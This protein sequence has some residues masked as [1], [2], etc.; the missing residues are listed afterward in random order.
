LSFYNK[1]PVSPILTGISLTVGADR[2]LMTRSL[3][4]VALALAPLAEGRLT[5]KRR[6][7]PP[8]PITDEDGPADRILRPPP[9]ADPPPPITDEDGSADLTLRPPPPANRHSLATLL[10]IVRRQPRVSAAVLFATVLFQEHVRIQLA[11]RKA[12]RRFRRLVRTKPKPHYGI[13]IVTTAALPWKTGTAVNALLRAANLAADHDVA[14]CVPWIHPVEQALLFPGG[15]SFATPAAQE[16]AMR[17]WLA[18][19]DGASATFRLRWYPARYDLVR[20]SILPL[21]DATKW[22]SG[23]GDESSDSVESVANDLCVLEEPEHLTWYHGGRNWRRAFKLVVG[24]VHTN[25]ISYAEL[26]QPENVWL[27]YLLN[28]IVVRAYTDASFKL[29]DSL[30]PLARSVV[31]N[32]HGV[33]NEFAETGRRVAARLNRGTA[34]D[35]R[36]EGAT[37]AADTGEGPFTEGAYFIGKLLWAKGHRLLIDYLHGGA[38]DT[39]GGGGDMVWGAG[40]STGGRTGGDTEGGA[41]SADSSAATGKDT[42]GRARGSVLVDDTGRGVGDTGG[43]PA[44]RW[45][46]V[47]V[48]GEGGDSD[49]IKGAVKSAEVDLRFLGAR[50]HADPSLD[51]YK[52]FVNPSQTEVRYINIY[53]YIYIYIYIYM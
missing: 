1:T 39:R 44:G 36:G 11:K 2:R 16:A 22:A 46:R 23:W 35:T 20:G 10:A 41:G 5:P 28:S 26:Y 9:P 45:T 25:Y 17:A 38:E 24:V 19:R 4:L 29:S 6:I 50:D 21:G 30:Q 37:A 33:R 27:V 52:V 32:V 49:A 48:F 8:P 47:D 40:V 15:A 51:K 13:T 12:L 7:P 3:L 53:T 18:E 42:A 14:L 43:G 31:C 34:D